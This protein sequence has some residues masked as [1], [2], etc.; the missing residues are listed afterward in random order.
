MQ[1]ENTIKP[2][3]HVFVCGGTG[4]G[5]SLLTEVYTAGMDNVIKIDIKN[6][7]ESRINEGKAPWFGL[8]EGEDFEVVRSLQGVKN[9]EFGKII[10]IPPEEEWNAETYDELCKFVYDNGNIRLWIDELILFTDGKTIANRW[11][12]AI[13]VSGRSRNATVIACTQRPSGIPQIITANVQ[14]Y[15]IFSLGKDADRKRMAQDIGSEQ[16]LEKPAKHAFWYYHDGYDREEIEQFM[17]P[18]GN[19]WNTLISS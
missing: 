1:I 18:L 7:Y 12:R 19:E 3:E 8:V 14:H 5:K 11:L 2:S 17:L 13:M 15:F 16:L 4:S 6:D 10:Y 9:S